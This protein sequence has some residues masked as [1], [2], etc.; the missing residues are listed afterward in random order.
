MNWR[1]YDEK[2]REEFSVEFNPETGEF[3]VYTTKIGKRERR[4]E[5]GRYLTY[6][7]VRDALFDKFYKDFDRPSPNA[8]AFGWNPNETVWNRTRAGREVKDSVS[9]IEGTKEIEVE[10][11]TPKE[12]TIKIKKAPPTIISVHS[13]YPQYLAGL[14]KRHEFAVKRM[15]R[16]K[17]KGFRKLKK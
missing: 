8:I 13:I 14:K 15:S 12:I 10:R 4:E 2:L 5:V 7:D 16:M 3:I 17:R 9:L 6:S 1:K 11:I